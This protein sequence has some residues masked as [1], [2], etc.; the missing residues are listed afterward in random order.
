MPR[1][2]VDVPLPGL[3]QI[4]QRDESPRTKRT[5][6]PTLRPTEAARNSFWRRVVKAPTDGGCFIFCGAISSPDGY[7]RIAWRSEGRERTLSAHRF[8]LELAYGALSNNVVAEHKCNE[9]LC[10]R[11]GPGHVVQSTQRD[12]LAYAVALGRATGGGTKSETVNRYARSLA[13][14]AA[15]C[16]GWDFEAYA[17]AQQAGRNANAAQLNLFD[18]SS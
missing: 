5:V 18:R 3:E 16:E 7:G 10:V 2:F 17:A 6:D 15:V 1:R 9:P 13:V 11:V 8:A 4:G 14:R 12:N